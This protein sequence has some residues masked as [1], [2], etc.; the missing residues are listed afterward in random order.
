MAGKKITELVQT[1]TV[2]DSDLFIVETANGTCSVPYSLIKT[3]FQNMLEVNAGETPFPFVDCAASHNGIFRG[4]DLTNIYTIDEI[5]ERIS[6]G[7]FEDL[8][9]G[10]YF[11]V[12]ISTEYTANEVVRCVLAGFDYYWNNG[13]IAFTNHHAVIVP[14][15][16]FNKIAQ[17]NSTNTTVGGFVNSYMWKTVLPIYTKALQS[18][19]NNHILSHKT[20]LTKSI[21]ENINSNAGAGIKGASNDCGSYDTLLS[22]LSEIQIHGS[23]IR[24]SSFYDIGH[25][26]LQLPLFA[27]DPTTKICGKN[28]T[29]DGNGDDNKQWYWLKNVVS[30]N[31]FAYVCYR[32]NYPFD[33]ASF[34]GGVRPIFCIG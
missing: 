19:L 18:A 23:N 11:D 15:N 34:T 9:I 30:V 1:N 26:D 17:M 24:S 12:I 29:T 4:K 21:D 7:T 3:L 33:N 16:C 22:L 27:L 32:S 20:I 13:N 5:C 2:D 10:D 25:D 6:N 31:T 28:T 8:Y 14:K